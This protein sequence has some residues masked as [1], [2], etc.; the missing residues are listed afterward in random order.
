MISLAMFRI[1][2][3]DYLIKTLSIMFGFGS[4]TPFPLDKF[5]DFKVLSVALVGLIFT[6]PLVPRF[7]KM[8]TTA[9]E[10]KSVI[11]FRL[12]TALYFSFYALMLLFALKEMTIVDKSPFIYF[13]F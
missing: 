9:R 10:Q 3:F 4:A 13:R 5:V 12:Y 1:E 6:M 2:N 7:K 11:K 8:I